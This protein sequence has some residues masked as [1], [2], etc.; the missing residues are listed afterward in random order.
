MQ[1]KWSHISS[2][3]YT[4]PYASSVE[5]TMVTADYSLQTWWSFPDCV[6]RET[7]QTIGSMICMELY[8]YVGLADLG[9]CF[10]DVSFMHARCFQQTSS[11]GPSFAELWRNPFSTSNANPVLCKK[12]IPLSK[13]TKERTVNWLQCTSCA[14]GCDAIFRFLAGSQ[15]PPVL[16]RSKCN[17]PCKAKKFRRKIVW[18][19]HV[20]SV[21]IITSY[22]WSV[23]AA[24][25]GM[26]NF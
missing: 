12:C 20:K 10:S 14:L 26:Q 6:W 15:P 4:C 5:I 16:M 17:R 2:V 3:C 24:G 19:N 23:G 1:H 7:S 25:K 11:M 8:G 21:Y 22:T 13:D 9:I 18:F